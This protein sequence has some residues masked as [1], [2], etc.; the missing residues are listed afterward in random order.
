MYH[1]SSFKG[2]ILIYMHYQE[3]LLSNQIGVY[4]TAK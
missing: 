3:N 2:L 1:N 4:P